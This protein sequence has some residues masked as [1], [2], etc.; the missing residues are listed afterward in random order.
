MYTYLFDKMSITLWMLVFLAIYCLEFSVWA[1][2][3]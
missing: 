2:G 1:W 3:R